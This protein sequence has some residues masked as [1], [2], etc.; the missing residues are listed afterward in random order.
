MKA[1]NA[2]IARTIIFILAMINQI[3]AV[4]GWTPLNL[5]EE[6]IY[7]VVSI[8]TFCGASIAAWWKDN[9][10]T[11]IAIESNKKMLEKKLLKKI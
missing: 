7:Q 10:F 5:S 9:A 8:I 2:T 4:M 11:K 3:C 6:L 1:S